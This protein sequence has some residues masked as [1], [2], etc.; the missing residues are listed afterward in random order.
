[1]MDI[2]TF[3]LYIMSKGNKNIQVS[4]STFGGCTYVA[5]ST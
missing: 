2:S 3:F 1:M 4:C 5:F